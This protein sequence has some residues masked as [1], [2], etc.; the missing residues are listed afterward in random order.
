[1]LRINDLMNRLTSLKISLAHLICRAPKMTVPFFP[2]DK[3]RPLY[4][5]FSGVCCFPKHL[6]QPSQPSDQTGMADSIATTVF[7]STVGWL[8]NRGR[9]VAATNLRHGDVFDQLLCGLV[10]RELDSIKSKLD[11][12][13]QQHLGAAVSS[14]MEGVSLTAV[15]DDL[16]GPGPAKR[17]K[18][19]TKDS[20]DCFKN[21]REQASLAFHNT[22]L[23]P[24]KRIL[25]V[26][27][28]IMARLLEKADDPAR[29]L[30]S[31]KQYIEEMHALE[32]IKSNFCLKLHGSPISRQ[33]RRVLSTEHRLR[34]IISSVYQVNRIVFGITQMI[35]VSNHFFVWPT[36]TCKC[37]SAEIDPLRDLL[38]SETLRK[39]DVNMDVLWTFDE[40]DK[41]AEN[42]LMCPHSIATNAQGE[43]LVLDNSDIK[44][45]DCS[46]RYLYSLADLLVDRKFSAVCHPID[47]E[48][49]QNGE[50]YLL[51]R[52]ANKTQKVVMLDNDGKLHS[53]SLRDKSKGRKLAVN[54]RGEST[55][56]LVLEGEKGLH[57]RVE[58]YETD[59]TFI[60]QF[61]ERILQD[62]Q[63][64]VGA[65]N[66]RVYVLD[67]CHESENKFIREFGARRNELHRF[68]VA[69]DCLSMAFHRPSQHIVVVSSANSRSLQ[70][71]I[72]LK[73]D[74]VHS[75]NFHLAGDLVNQNVTVSAKGRIAVVYAVNICGAHQGNVVVY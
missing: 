31:C 52:M 24:E 67:K 27:I 26:Y 10:S 65:N 58:V 2:L 60:C 70:L 21:A 48:S 72:Y 71:S 39:E 62:A 1:M 4:I 47:I 32:E 33:L 56:V 40:N 25:A 23:S 44:V 15:E 3:H 61:G 74:L 73:A 63:D 11:G 36:V 7:R 38:F 46:G 68:A 9:T 6:C 13:A 66:G 28:R 12:L 37:G 50:V 20:N 5:A 35:G 43:Y 45:F 51:V 53:F 34:D 54:Q 49:D 17:P 41:H 59:G 22:D 64:I 57:A 19:D 30:I 14:Y 42:R 29:A 8:I 18:L 55:E 75:Q 16:D 69:P